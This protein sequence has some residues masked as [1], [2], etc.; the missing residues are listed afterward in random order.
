[1]IEI[2]GIKFGVEQ[3]ILLLIPLVLGITLF[4]YFRREKKLSLGRWL[5]LFIRF[6][7]FSLIIIA[8]SS[9]YTFTTK[10]EP[11]EI[12]IKILEDSSASMK[13]YNKLGEELYNEISEKIKNKSSYKLKFER[14]SESSGRTE[15]GNALYQESIKDLR[16]DILL[17]ISDGNN[18][19]AHKPEDVAKLLS[20]TTKIFSIMPKL[21]KS[22]I[23]ISEIIGERTIPMNTEYKVL[24]K[25]SKI[26][27]RAGYSLKFI[28]DGNV[29]R[30]E[31]VEQDSNIREFE[32]MISFVKPGI[33][34]IA[35]EVTPYSED[36]FTEN[37]YV[38]KIVEVVER[39]QILVISKNSNSPLIRVLEKNYKVFVSK[40]LEEGFQ[41][42]DLVVLDDQNIED[43]SVNIVNS[44][45]NYLSSGNGL[46]VIGGENSFDRGNYEN[47]NFERILPVIS[48]E[49]P[50]EKRKPIAVTFL[51]DVSASMGYKGAQAYETYVD[52]EKAIAINL[53]RQLSSEDS[54][55]VLAFNVPV[56]TIIDLT[57]IGSNKKLIEENILKLKAS[58]TGGTNFLPALSKAEEILQEYE[59]E[60]YI[61]FLSDG[62]PGGEKKEAILSK[63]KSIANKGIKI[64]SVSVGDR[65]QAKEGQE[66]MQEI[67]RES[68]G[69]YFWMEENQRLSAV[70]REEEESSGYHTVKI[71]NPYHFITEGLRIDTKI[72]DLNG[73]SA[74]TVAQVLI[75]TVD[76]KPVV[77]VWR[78]GLGRVAAITTD[79]GALWAGNLYTAEGGKL[80]SRIMNWAI[81]DLEKKKPLKITT[82]DIFLGDKASI[83]IKTEEKPKVYIKEKNS[84]K[85]FDA[86][87]VDI[88]L[89]SL[90]FTPENSGIY[91][92]T[93]E[94]L[95]GKD[96][97]AIAVNQREEYFNLGIDI[98]RLRKISELTNG[99]LYNFTEKGSTIEEILNYAKEKSV[100]KVNSRENLQD[101][102][103]FAALLLFFI[104]VIT[105]RVIEILKLSKS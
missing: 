83:M 46:V 66:L 78:F 6:V 15:I 37:N 103:I 39:P 97:D 5:F 17:L 75:S 91:E 70:F 100:M 98:E 10:E 7:L 93:A 54:V 51:I 77:T 49:K 87:Q 32:F 71:Y 94:N 73:V 18:N 3:P 43:L 76:K 41:N 84:T 86:K 59:N 63:V 89:F 53:L 61:I 21:N 81:Y 80:I 69:L 27:G 35:V 90:S 31:R 67:A 52:E 50:K 92:I 60:A 38:R 104:D 16:S 57:K 23:Y 13:I 24:V 96:I 2:Y 72:N 4:L 45:S 19:Y 40:K 44:L 8:I 64:Y 30:A 102:F 82:D 29:L 26:G 68:N 33:H 99:N 42:Y 105:R 36:F 101:Y 14:F 65:T 34:T 25:I 1:M 47:S 22:E 74:K 56:Y 95:F 48:G 28:V 62:V 58:S 9:P 88:G 79:N 12:S 20:D 55:A 11:R 85:E